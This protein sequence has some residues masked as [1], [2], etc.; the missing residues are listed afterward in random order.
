MVRLAVVLAIFAIVN[1]G[2]STPSP[3]APDTSSTYYAGDPL[4]P[5]QFG[6][7]PNLMLPPPA[8]T[9]HPAGIVATPSGHGYWIVSSNGGVF[10]FGDASFH[11]SMGAVAL[12]A[13]IVG[14][15]ATPSG[16][17][18]W[19]VAAD[20]GV[21]S[22]G[23]AGFAGS[24]GGTPLNAP[25]VGIATTPSGNGYWLVAAD[26]GVFSFGDA[27]FAGSMGGTPLNAPIV[28]I[29]AAH[30][31]NGYWL[32]AADG[33]VFSFGDAGFAGSMGGTPLNA[34]IVGIAAAHTGNGYWLVAADGGVFSFGDA[35]FHGSAGI[36]SGSFPIGSMA[37]T[38]DGGG[39]W[40]LPAPMTRPADSIP[41]VIDDCNLAL[42][43]GAESHFE[44]S[45]I[46]LACA[47]GNSGAQDLAWTSWTDTTAVGTGEFFENHC[48]PS[49]AA[50]TFGY[51][52]ATFSLS[53]VVQTVVG[54]LFSEMSVAYEGTGPQ[55][56]RT[57][58]FQLSMPPS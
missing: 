48:V 2:L 45:W 39:Y 13:P 24:M 58:Q 56:E 28:G 29:A 20:G 32:V 25:I 22:F 15:G 40:L 21:F 41:E 57:D 52:P 10:T 14:I 30:T 6:D 9:G 54:P 50:G 19:L 26:G 43:E 8:Y 23:D 27:G 31:G 51:Y 18:Y 38:A 1:G 34:P 4:L 46:S 53:G 55:G 37:A 11:G 7:A 3:A 35:A 47:D 16:N 5:L 49:C 17:G 44:P 36:G 33:G 42:P 12:N